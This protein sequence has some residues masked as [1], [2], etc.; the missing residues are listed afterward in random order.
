MSLADFQREDRRLLIMKALASESDYAISDVVLRSLL[1]EFGHSISMDVLHADLAWLQDIGLL[2]IE[3]AAS[4]VVA[5]ATDRGVEVA[6]G[7]ATIPGIR[8]PR[9]GE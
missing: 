5:T 1:A 8:R 3:K 4:M 2:N 6:E 9:P 7:H